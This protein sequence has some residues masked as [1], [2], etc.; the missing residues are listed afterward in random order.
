MTDPEI[1]KLWVP[2]SADVVR[3][4]ILDDIR[5]AMREQGV[6]L[7]VSPKTDTYIWA[8][9]DA[10]A[11]MIQYSQLAT[12]SRSITPLYSEGDDLERW[13]QALGLPVAEPGPSSGRIRLKVTGSSTVTADTQLVLENGKRIKVYG[14][15]SGVV[16]GDEID[17]VAIDTGA[18]TN[19]AGGTTVRFVTAPLNVE[20]EATVS[21]EIPLSGGVDDETEARKL[22]RVLNRMANGA[23]N[24]G[25]WGGLR[26]TAFDALASVQDCFVFPA[27]GGP[28]SCKIV[29]VRGFDR[30][31]HLYT[32]E[33]T[34]AALAIIRHAIHS[35]SSDGNQYVVQAAADENLDV[36]LML[37]L[38]NSR[39]S[40]GNGNGWLD[41]AP[42]PLT[43]SSTRVRVDAVS[44]STP[45][46]TVDTDTT[47]EPVDGQTRI[48]W[49]SP[50][51]MEFVTRLV[52][53]HSGS[54]GAWV[55][56]LDT[57]MT[58]SAGN[59]PSVDDF[60]SPGME[61]AEAYAKTWI[62]MMEALGCGENISSSVLEPRDS[63]RPFVTDGPATG[64]STTQLLE[65]QKRNP[66]VTSVGWSYVSLGA[67]TVPSSI[68]D[69]PNIL[70]PRH[71]GIYYS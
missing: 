32:R 62:D 53:S 71:F 15:W 43:G 16:D 69:P 58:D 14:S 12:L 7:P 55:L 25:N 51:T 38:P 57:P 40:G 8:T 63:R 54:A 49:W 64:V 4:D 6:T 18:D 27:L 61:N 56:T 37:T 5:L 17:V 21:Y 10:N 36:A 65:F 34:A 13:R 35:K 48:A 66:E 45:S 23:D 68:D 44:S 42:W 41:A 70:V 9:A 50:H 2:E 24:S 28:A 67:P 20:S 19:A 33:F 3:Q 59:E 11:A 26:G 1:G 22:T 31:N 46:I 30:T 29:P 39:L 52:V 47:T 60:V